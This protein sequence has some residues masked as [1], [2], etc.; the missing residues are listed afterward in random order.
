MSLQHTEVV[1]HAAIPDQKKPE[2][3]K[4]EQKQKKRRVTKLIDLST[5]DP[6]PVDIADPEF[7]NMHNDDMSKFKWVTLASGISMRAH[8]I[9]VK[10]IWVTVIL[11]TAVCLINL[12]AKTRSYLD[13][14]SDTTL[15][16]LHV[17]VM[18]VWY[19]LRFLF[20]SGQ[21]HTLI[22]T[23]TMYDTKRVGSRLR[24]LRFIFVVGC[25]TAILVIYAGWAVPIGMSIHS[26]TE[27]GFS[28][29]Y[30]KI[31]GP[32]LF[33]III[34][35]V[36]VFVGNACVFNFIC[37][38]VYINILRTGDTITAIFEKAANQTTRTR[39]SSRHVIEHLFAPIFPVSPNITSCLPPVSPNPFPVFSVTS[40]ASPVI[41]TISPTV[42]PTSTVTTPT[43]SNDEDSDS[44]DS[45]TLNRINYS[46]LDIPAISRIFMQVD[47]L[48][49]PIFKCLSLSFVLW[50]VLCTAMMV[51]GSKNFIS[52][53]FLGGS[54]RGAGT[55]QD[56]IIMQSFQWGFYFFGGLFMQLSILFWAS[57]ITTHWD[58][59]Q[60]RINGIPLRTK[61]MINSDMQANQIIVNS[62]DT[63]KCGYYAFEIRISPGVAILIFLISFEI[64]FIVNLL[65]IA[66]HNLG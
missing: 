49:R 8:V 21:L 18:Y 19:K 65:L 44:D 10:M 3:K 29:T 13:P 40:P 46:E 54:S 31:H 15:V 47:E 37:L 38:V 33:V 53:I 26:Q 55:D 62:I 42:S 64:V 7:Y 41:S 6:S 35:W 9:W 52:R 30:L 11:C 32:I 43:S 5:P 27:T 45:N 60:K 36:F 57:E 48:C 24:L 16:F 12:F 39:Q 58:R 63:Q 2:Q 50:N 4:S 17:M 20:H 1:V 22:S 23:A 28:A 66:K 56:D 59:L 14:P 51:V 61:H 25:V 34:P